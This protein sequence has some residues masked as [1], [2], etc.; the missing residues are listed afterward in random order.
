M[1]YN[2]LYNQTCEAVVKVNNKSFEVV[3]FGLTDKSPAT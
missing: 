2:K 1:S 3:E